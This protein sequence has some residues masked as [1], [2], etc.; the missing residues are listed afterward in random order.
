VLKGL[1]ERS[2][3][4]RTAAAEQVSLAVQ[5]L[6]ARGATS[7]VRNLVEFLAENFT[8]SQSATHRKGGLAGIAAAATALRGNTAAYLDLFL[9]SVLT[10]FS[11]SDSSVRQMA[12]SSLFNILQMADEAALPYLNVMFVGVCKLAADVD[13]D[14]KNTLD[15]VDNQLKSMVT[16]AAQSFD[17]ASF[18]PLLRDHASSTDMYVRRLFVSWVTTLDSV[19]EINMLEYLPDI[20]EGL[21][22]MLS[23]ANREVRTDAYDCLEDFLQQIAAVP[24]AEFEECV[25]LQPIVSTLV[26]FS[27]AEARFPRVTA[28]E[29]LYQLIDLAGSIVRPVFAPVLDTVLARLGDTQQD[30]V[31]MAFK[32][33]DLLMALVQRTDGEVGMEALLHI[34]TETLPSTEQLQRSEALRWLQMLLQK[35][36]EDVIRRVDSVLTALLHNLTDDS[37]VDVL[38]LNLDTLARLALHDKAYFFNTILHRMLQL[39]AGDRRLLEARGGFIIRRLCLLLDARDI[40][41]AFSRL[42]VWEPRADFV[43][44]FIE[45]LSLILLTAGEMGEFRALLRGAVAGGGEETG[46]GS[47]PSTPPSPET[48][49]GETAVPQS[50]STAVAAGGGIKYAADMSSYELF[51]V[52]FG[53]WSH[54]PVATVT[55]CLLSEAYEV[56]HGIVASL[57]ERQ[58]TVG[59]LMQL[60]KLVQLIESPVFVTMR[61]HLVHPERPDHAHLLRC[62]YALLMLLPQSAAFTVL[63]D[64][65]QSVTSLHVALGSGAGSSSGALVLPASL[66]P[67]VSTASA[68]VLATRKGL[69]MEHYMRA[70][71]WRLANA[72]A[73]EAPEG[74][75]APGEAEMAAAALQEGTDIP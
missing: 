38:K 64:R 63:R 17:T 48:G 30:I 57:V 47:L 4:R 42:L 59:L 12:L 22:A 15:L 18:V 13:P 6:S 2:A 28:V 72:A 71:Q 7:E 67:V 62:L 70:Q 43:A 75:T 50:S 58:I 53:T 3:E 36:P 66:R 26:R 44:V 49:R 33:S 23:D 9:P 37:S 29:W 52:L 24:L 69:L 39:L 45:L 21:F 68:A 55:L 27:S 11:D 73:A 51:C 8:Q 41:L 10:C 35:A 40:Y 19:P 14:V 16:H 5:N 31:E 65:I 56:A 54:N 61:V 25:A 60:D 20:M 1:F 46:A 74:L 32:T 34:I